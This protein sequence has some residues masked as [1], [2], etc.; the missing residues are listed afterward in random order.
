MYVF[1]CGILFA[2]Q[3]AEKPQTPEAES[4]KVRE[5]AIKEIEIL[6]DSKESEVFEYSTL[7]KKDKIFEG[8]IKATGIMTFVLMALVILL[9][10][11]AKSR[12]IILAHKIIALL[13]FITASTHLV[14]NIIWKK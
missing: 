11:M 5:K 10:L 1:S 12:K 8:L 6:D 14:L 7:S 2:A 9:G 13:M 4:V 3:N